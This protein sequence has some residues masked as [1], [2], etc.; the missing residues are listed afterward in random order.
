MLASVSALTSIYQSPEKRQLTCMI[1]LAPVNSRSFFIA[2]ERS[3]SVYDTSRFS[4][5]VVIPLFQSVLLGLFSG[6]AAGALASMLE[7]THAPE[8]AWC[9]ASLAALFCWIR[10]VSDWIRLRR[11]EL[12]GFQE[13]ELISAPEPDPEIITAPVRIE[14]KSERSLQLIDLPISQE[15]IVTFASSIIAGAPISES[16]WT[17]AGALFSKREFHMLRDELIKRG[18]LAWRN[19]GAPACGLS[20]TRT[21]AATMR[22]FASVENHLR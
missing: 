3:A 18:M 16:S 15:K 14:L 4:I 8:L 10:L 11:L 17:G 6:V 1:V 22:Y 13:P 7:L 19:T 21:G 5:A 9:I 20:L 12:I 2:P